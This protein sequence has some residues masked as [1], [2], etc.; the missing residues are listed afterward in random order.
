MVARR[1]FL[2]ALAAA[3]VVYGARRLHSDDWQSLDTD[4]PEFTTASKKSMASGNGWMK[5]TFNRDQGCG[6]DIGTPSDI[7]CT[8]MVGL[9]LMS[10]AGREA[11]N[12]SK[13]SPAIMVKTG[14]SMQCAMPRFW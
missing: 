11:L 10:Q 8:A 3:P 12:Q 2:A 13:A 7:S 14:F 1:T 5:K 4:P 9:A 6:I